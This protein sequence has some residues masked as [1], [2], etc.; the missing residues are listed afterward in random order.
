MTDRYVLRLPGGEP[1]VRDA[2]D[3]RWANP[4]GASDSTLG[5]DSWALPGLVD[6]HAHFAAVERA[7]WIT[8][9]VA[10]AIRRAGE[11]LVA[12][13]MLALD[14]GW[15]DLTTIEMMSRIGLADRPDIEAAGIILSVRDGYWPDFGREVGP[16][17]MAQVVTE[18]AA[19][20]KGWVKLVGDWPRRGVGPLPNFTESELGEAVRVA[21]SFGA[22]VAIHTMA[23]EVPSMAVGAG[24]H[25]IE[26][27]LFLTEGDVIELGARGGI[28]VPTVLRMEA[29]VRQLGADSSGGRLVRQGIENVASLL[30]SA[31]EAGVFVLA[32]TDLAVGT[33]AV[34]AEAIRL[35]ELG[36]SPALVVDAVSKAGLRATGRADAFEVGSP[37]NVVLYPEDPVTDP[38]VLAHPQHVVRLG[39]LL[40]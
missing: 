32:G 38:R 27:G 3:G 1:L 12:G 28:W 14:K 10:G 6:G 17:K 4:A 16:G 29:V 2:V 20:S 22:R 7:D 37:A 26:H 24:V 34:A 40:A 13:V 23:R 33:R 30:N 39:R 9:D 11:A 18:A 19:E 5:D 25:S 36:M 21:E 15:N 35:W 31:A 8:D